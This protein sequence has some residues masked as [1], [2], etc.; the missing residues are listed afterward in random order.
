VSASFRAERDGE[1]VCFTI[2]RPEAKN[3]LDLATIVG[4]TQAIRTTPMRVAILTGAGDTFVSGGDLRELRGRDSPADAEYLTDIGFELT[5][6]IAEAPFPVI[7][8]LNGP[9][10]GGGA[11]LALACDLRIATPAPRIELKQVHM[12]VTTSWGTA[13][14]LREL[15]GRSVATRLLF[16]LRL[17]SPQ[18][19]FDAGLVDLA[20][21]D[22]KAAALQI[23]HEIER[24]PP[25]AIAAM[26]RLMRAPS[27]SD[28]RALERR[29]FVETWSSS[30]HRAAVEAWF[31]RAK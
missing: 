13:A 5:T 21:D 14:R 6:A 31:R 9:A 8:A 25:S 4:L 12:A 3:A 15:V 7:A 26:K 11:E 19:L 27:G 29:L 10:I 1:V 23:A 18:A 2:D 22:P 17:P 30:E 28:L 24:A 20:A 16:G